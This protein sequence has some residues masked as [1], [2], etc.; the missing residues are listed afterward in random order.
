MHQSI[1]LLG[2]KSHNLQSDIFSYEHT[3]L[4][5]LST[6]NKQCTLDKLSFLLLFLRESMVK[7][8]KKPYLNRIYDR[9]I[10]VDEVLM[11]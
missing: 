5:F 6:Y 9:I 11:I 1:F 8:K 10:I 4:L 3:N 2:F 7:K